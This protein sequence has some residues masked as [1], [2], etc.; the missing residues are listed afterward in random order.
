[1][2]LDEFREAIRVGIVAGAYDAKYVIK[3]L[4]SRDHHTV[5]DV[6]EHERDGYMRALQREANR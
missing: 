2:T 1:M 4:R 5:A 6:P 3:L